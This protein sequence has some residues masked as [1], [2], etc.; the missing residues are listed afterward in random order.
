MKILEETMVLFVCNCI[1]TLVCTSLS[2]L[3]IG[4]TT[5]EREKIKGKTIQL[6]HK[7]SSKTK[8]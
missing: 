7:I 5:K 3:Y 6:Y 1:L 8:A 2:V 4:C